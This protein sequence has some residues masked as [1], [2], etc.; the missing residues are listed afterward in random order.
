MAFSNLPA[1]FIPGAGPA[2]TV[3]AETANVNNYDELIVA[4]RGGFT[5]II[6]GFIIENIESR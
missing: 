3:Y 2:I 1:G 4:M 5:D 6:N